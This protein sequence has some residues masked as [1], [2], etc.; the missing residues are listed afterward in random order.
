[1][2]LAKKSDYDSKGVRK[3]PGVPA[4]GFLL[5]I[6]IIIKQHSRSFPIKA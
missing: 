4:P 2:N 5:S 6:F 1:M 3:K